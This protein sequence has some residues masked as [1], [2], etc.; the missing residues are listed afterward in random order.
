MNPI[1]LFNK[2]TSRLDFYNCEN[3]KVIFFNLE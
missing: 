2:A 3:L 1:A